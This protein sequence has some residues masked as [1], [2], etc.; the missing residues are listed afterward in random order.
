MDK[1]GKARRITVVGSKR[2]LVHDYIFTT[3]DGAERP[4]NTQAANSLVQLVGMVMAAPLIVQALGKEKIYEMFNEIFR[5][6]GAGLD[7]N[8]TLK[9]GEDDSVGPDEM[10]QM[11]ATL[12]KIT[13]ILQQMGGQIQHSAQQIAEQEQ[14]NQ[15]QGVMLSHLGTLADQVHMAVKD[16]DTLK[17]KHLDI[18]KRL[19]ETLPYDKAPF[20]I[21][22]QMEAQAGFDPAPDSERTKP[23]PA[24]PQPT[25]KK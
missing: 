7:L 18:Q 23:A 11:K 5:L 4:V 13:G 14:V 6:S 21:Q 17:Q 3:R 24:K 10:E 2:F 19:T 25:T 20:S 12:D 9:E 8:L 1:Q 22:R 15:K 16:V